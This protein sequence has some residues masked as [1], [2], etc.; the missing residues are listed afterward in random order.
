MSLLSA[1][2]DN[3]RMKKSPYKITL[4]LLIVSLSSFSQT[5]IGTITN[6]YNVPI[7]NVYVLNRNAN[8]HIHT[9]SKG[10]FS[11]EN[12]KVGDSLQLSHISYKTI[13]VPVRA[14]DTPFNIQLREQ[15]VDLSEI[16]IPKKLNALNV[17]VNIN[18]KNTPVN[19]SQDILKTVPGLI[20]GQHAGGGKSEQIFL[21]GFD[22]DHG[23]DIQITVEGMPV[24]IVSHAHGQGY[25]DLHFVIPETIDKIDF[26]K[27]PYHANK[28]NFATAG[29]IDFQLK[30][31]I[32][33]SQVK[34]EGGSFNTQR[35]SGLFN[36]LNQ[37]N[38]KA[39]IA[40]EYLMTDGP[41]K[42]PQNFNRINMMARYTEFLNSGGKVSFIA[43][44][45]SS[46]WDASGQIPER[47]VPI[48]G[49]FG[50]IDDTEG[51]TTHRTNIIVKYDKKLEE[52]AM[53]KN[54]MY[55]VNYDF[56]LFSNFTFFLNNP[57]QGDQIKQKENRKIFGVN[58][59]Y[60]KRFDYGIDNDGVFISGVGFRNDKSIENEL[61]YTKNRTLTVKTLKLGDIDETNMYAF[62]DSRFNIGK[63]TVNPGLRLD[64]FKFNYH[65]HLKVAYSVE[66][67]QKSILS[68][69][70]NFLFNYSNNLQLFLKTGKGFHSNDTRVV[71]QSVGHKTLPAAYGSDIGMVWKP[72]PKVI[73]STAFWYLF[74][75]QEFVYVGDE[76]VVESIGNT[77]RLGVDL[78][79]MYYPL[80][81][82][83]LNVDLNYAKPKAI[84]EPKGQDFV[85]LAPDLTVAGGIRL[86]HPSGLFGAAKFLFVKDRPAN[87][88][89][90]IVAKGYS[91][92]DVN[93]GYRWSKITLGIELRNVLDTTW[94][95]TQ[96][97]TESR[98][99]N[100]VAP[101]TEIHFTP[102]N[103][104][105]VKGSITYSF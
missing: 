17:F 93:I 101:V 43:S 71:V 86:N 11:L 66:S 10:V 78:G 74:S 90:S 80:D 38:K 59:V 62:V 103:P 50:A 70:L 36:L 19:N 41:F 29:Y 81:W 64:Y 55:Y 104:F 30:E 2:K 68:P 84:E 61:S 34:L 94:N 96:F 31:Q 76:A 87:E 7:E 77:Q 12:V 1:V 33:H 21:R 52:D 79:W 15:F 72:S 45:F 39:Y 60:S 46:D 99:K 24:N 56:E 58:S 22:V 105:N 65:D 95:E 83:S 91:L 4:L 88:D 9:N 98:L 44:Y 69:K 82:L 73:L 5:I 92:L 67:A 6:S 48:I 20:I 28:G 8:T 85:P 42:S 75:E 37:G 100:E 32:D 25:A 53:V 89:N 13:I 97:A 18:L 102:G 3:K 40:T 23:T 14:I 26:D 16:V 27:G 54:S 57:I 63:W 35:I 49:R 51:G 47:V